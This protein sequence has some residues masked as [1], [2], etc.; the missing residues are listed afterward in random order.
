MIARSGMINLLPHLM[1]LQHASIHSIGEDASFGLLCRGLSLA[2]ATPTWGYHPRAQHGHLLLVTG[3]SEGSGVSPALRKTSG[4]GGGRRGGGVA[5]GLPI[6]RSVALS[7]LPA[8]K[9][10]SA[11]SY[12]VLHARNKV[13]AFCVGGSQRFCWTS[14]LHCCHR[15]VNTRLG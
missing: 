14:L 9:V 2:P 13:H 8:L 12:L 4:G 3:N 1:L 5:I 15:G 11:S 7:A 6:H 10:L